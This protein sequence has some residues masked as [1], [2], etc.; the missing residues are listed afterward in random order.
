MTTVSEPLHPKPLFPARWGQAVRLASIAVIVIC[1][2]ALIRLLPVA[3]LTSLL[4][5][6]IEQIGPWG[7]ALFALIY[8]L[9]AVLFVPGSTL[10]IAA[11]AIFGL[12]WGMV[13]VSAGSTAGAAAA[14]LIA[15]YFARGA[16]ERKLGKYSK[17]RA[18]DRAVSQGGWKIVALL[19]LSPVV[20]FNLQNYLYGLTAIRF[21]PCILA[22]WLAMLPGTFLYVYLGYAGRAGLAAAAGA[23]TGRGLG[24]WM[25]LGAG[26]LATVVV[27]V[28]V[29]RL[30]SRAVQEQSQATRSIEQ[31]DQ[32]KRVQPDQQRQ[33]RPVGTLLL[34][35]AAMA[36]LALAVLAYTDPSAVVGLFGPPK[37]T[38]S[39]AYR[40]NPQGPGFDHSPYDSL[41]KQHVN[42]RGGVD[43]AGLM[44]DQGRL[45]DY[46]GSIG[47]APFD[48]LGRDGKLALL[49]NAYNAFTLEL[50]LEHWQDGRLQSIRDI[51]SEQRW[52]D[53]RWKVG[54]Q[55][56]SLNQIEHEQIRPKFREPRVHWAL[57]CAAVSCP[58]LRAEAYASERLDAQLEEQARYV[59]AH[60]RWFRWLLERG[61]VGLTQL[62]QW[63]GGDFEQTDGSL[64]EYASRYA[65]QL[66]SALQAG[67]KPRIEWLEYDWRLNTQE[68]IP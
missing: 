65:P 4:A 42:G 30:A 31:S 55:V 19:R 39:E 27:T 10:T 33:P 66:K 24:E 53:V 47:E 46:L 34:A 6:W 23:E 3:Q 50:I 29:S 1:L 7:P 32:A 22:S 25:L 38:M 15:R 44:R 67:R 63:Y 68:N 2:I 36:F 12:F 37:V 28:Y 5:G 11:G 13:A 56:W 20:P 51:P 62:Y 16:I 14:F 57:V 17:F 59:H 49:I 21:W 61:V 45:Q 52:D 48:E 35:L 64:L 26:L 8:L 58:P 18:I 40:P 60:P 41:L 9:A 43:Y 54:K